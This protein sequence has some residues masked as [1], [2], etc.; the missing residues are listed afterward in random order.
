MNNN[1]KI[2]AVVTQFTLEQID[3]SGSIPKMKDLQPPVVVSFRAIL[4]HSS[5]E[6]DVERVLEGLMDRVQNEHLEALS[7]KWKIDD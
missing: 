7:A 3:E 4:P 2:L 5:N 6:R 1:P